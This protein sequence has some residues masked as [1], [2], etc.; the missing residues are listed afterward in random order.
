VPLTVFILVVLF[1]VQ[2]GG[3][4]RV[5]SAF[6]P[7]M[8]IW[9]TALA[10]MGLQVLEDLR[11]AGREVDQDHPSIV[12]VMTSLDHTTGGHPGD[13]PGRAGN[14]HV[15][16]L[17]NSAHRQ[18]TLGLEHGQDAQVDQAQVTVLPAPEGAH[19]LARRPGRQ[20]PDQ[21][22]GQP[23]APARGLRDAMFGA[24]SQ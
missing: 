1:A 19:P 8:V 2:S 7:V 13:D 10:V 12:R 23:G 17:G 6:G 11:A 3:T 24:D 5:A 21:V 16:L 20:L 9:F 4:A 22:V 15:E 14:R 18:G